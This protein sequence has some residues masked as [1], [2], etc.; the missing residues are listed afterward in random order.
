M[1]FTG[2]KIESELKYLKS[3]GSRDEASGYGAAYEST[4]YNSWENSKYW[5]SSPWRNIICLKFFKWEIERVNGKVNRKAI[6]F[7]CS[8]FLFL[9]WLHWSLDY[10]RK[11]W[12]TVKFSWKN[13]LFG[14]SGHSAVNLKSG[15]LVR[16]IIGFK[17]GQNNYHVSKG[18]A[19]DAAFTDH[20]CESAENV[21]CIEEV[22]R[23]AVSQYGWKQLSLLLFLIP[24]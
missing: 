24:W 9:F 11:C 8:F 20:G 10:S 3:G 15:P 7:S 18:E 19:M 1:E 5:S 12:N 22:P 13:L 2:K 14:P 16:P 23:P 4:G 6:F 17:K 21:V